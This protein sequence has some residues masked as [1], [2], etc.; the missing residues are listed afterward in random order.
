METQC[1]VF[2]PQNS[3][4]QWPRAWTKEQRKI[5]HFCL[6]GPHEIFLKDRRFSLISISMLQRE[7]FSHGTYRVHCR[8]GDVKK[9]LKWRD[10]WSTVEDLG[11]EVGPTQWETPKWHCRVQTHCYRLLRPPDR[12]EPERMRLPQGAVRHGWQQQTQKEKMLWG[13]G[14]HGGAATWK[15]I[16]CE[17]SLGLHILPWEENEQRSV[18]YFSQIYSLS[19]T[20]IDKTLPHGF[21]ELHWEGPKK[22][23]WGN[24]S[25]V[26]GEGLCL[27]NN[28]TQLNHSREKPDD[29]GKICGDE[30]V[31][32]EAGLD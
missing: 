13:N 22:L 32:L 26:T 25:P 12:K 27:T 1:A 11:T 2:K 15:G 6:R 24:V 19:I 21:W 31:T 29:K 7:L 28:N 8:R 10:S 20:N 23:K 30:E 18:Q 4:N 16:F 17:N 14:N 3:N 5:L 9:A